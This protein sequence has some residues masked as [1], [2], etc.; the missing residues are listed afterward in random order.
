MRL[1]RFIGSLIS[2]I[3]SFIGIC[4]CE[5]FRFLGQV[6]CFSIKLSFR[7]T[8]AALPALLVLLVLTQPSIQ[9]EIQSGK[10]IIKTTNVGGPV[11]GEFGP[12]PGTRWNQVE[13]CGVYFNEQE[14]FNSALQCVNENVWPDDP[15]AEESMIPRCFVVSAESPDVFSDGF[16]V[17]V[18]PIILFTPFGI[19]QSAIVGYYDTDTNSIFIVE[20]EDAAGIYRHELQHLFLDLH[21]EASDGGGHFQ[22]IWQACEPPYYKPSVRAQIQGILEDY[23]RLKNQQK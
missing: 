23:E 17:N 1:F 5:F 10:V 18:V 22:Y 6:L 9:R 8:L 15:I 14:E 11:G 13:P 19:V 21:D 3:F 20:N 7:V 16:G 4:I 2:E 12:F